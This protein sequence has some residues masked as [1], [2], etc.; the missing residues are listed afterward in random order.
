MWALE[1]GPSLRTAALAARASLA[2]PT[3]VMPMSEGQAGGAGTSA[4]VTP[5]SC[6]QSPSWLPPKPR[7]LFTPIASLASHS[8]VPSF[9]QL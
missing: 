6:S 3:P 1:P 5:Q 2:A 7:P 8:P 9:P 4:P